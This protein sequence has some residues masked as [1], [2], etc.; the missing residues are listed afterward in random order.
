ME[1]LESGAIRP[2]QSAWCNAVV[3]VRK[4]RWWLTFKYPLLTFEH[5][6]EEGFLSITPNSRLTREF[7]GHRSFFLSGFE[8]W[9]L[10]NKNGRGIKAVYHLH[11][12]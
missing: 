9:I 4:K 3:L 1:M 5:T 11:H 7:S 8:V 12:G 10:A 6:Y 2:S